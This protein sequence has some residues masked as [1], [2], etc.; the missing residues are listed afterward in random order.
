MNRKGRKGPQMQNPLAGMMDVPGGIPAGGF[1]GIGNPN[2]AQI[3]FNNDE[4]EDELADLLGKLDVNKHFFTGYIHSR[5]QSET[6][7]KT[8]SS[9]KE[10]SSPLGS[11]G[12]Y[13]K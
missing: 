8:C 11:T 10:R 9:T 12:F 5:R 4:L 1:L 7:K 2:G 6:G 3:N 13:D